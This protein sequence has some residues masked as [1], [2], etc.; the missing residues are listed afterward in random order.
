[1]R[2]L[3]RDLI[4]EAIDSGWVAPIGP[5]LDAFEEEAARAVGVGHA[6]GL[7]SGTAALHLAMLE[8][9][10]EP[11]DD[12]LV[13]TFTFVAT[14][15]AVR[16][17]GANPV[18]IDSDRA[19]WNMSP[20]LLEAE[21][22]ERARSGKPV[23]AAVVVDLYGQCAD[24]ARIVPLLETH[25]VALVEDA[26]E[27]LGATLHDRP[28]GSFGRCAVLSFNG[29]K[30]I[31]S[32]GGGM[33]LADDEAFVARIRHLATQAREPAPHYEH[34]EVGFNYRLSNLLAAFGL[35][36]LRALPERIARR[37]VI[38]ERY[39]DALAEVDGV[40]FAPTATGSSPNWWLTCITIDAARAGTDREAVRIRL[41]AADIESRPLWKPMHLQPLFAGISARIDGTSEQLFK[42]GL[43]LPSGSGMTD[44]E[45]G[46]VI[47]R[48]LGAFSGARVND[49]G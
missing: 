27:A 29:N 47:D 41:E 9:G 3:E 23:K 39:R 36:Q 44:D 8:L 43:C 33:L 5:H 10:V 30:I 38:N 1:V 17:L 26:A 22:A 37:Q 14:A 15:N 19:S 12:V 2:P 45:Q 40:E 49:S 18:F 32:S 4:L 48:L 34:V 13:S 6:V 42:S 35:G 21:L 25:G 31:T 7:S 24:Y 11:G 28:A 20:E 46:R 16:Y